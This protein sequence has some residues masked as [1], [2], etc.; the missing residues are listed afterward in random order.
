MGATRKSRNHNATVEIRSW[1]PGG[2]RVDPVV[3]VQQGNHAI[4][5]AWGPHSPLEDVGRRVEDKL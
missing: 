5:T 3:W 4:T 1:D 2:I